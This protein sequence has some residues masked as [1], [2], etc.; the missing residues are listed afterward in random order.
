MKNLTE[1]ELVALLDKVRVANETHPLPMPKYE[2]LEAFYA[3][4]LTGDDE[5]RVSE[6]LAF[7]PDVAEAM[8]KAFP[9]S[10]DV[11]T[12]EQ[13]SEQWNTFSGYGRKS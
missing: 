8:L 7:N 5:A 3:G 6:Y 11:L 9:E 12:R 1:S 13:I 10:D 4:Q 2:E